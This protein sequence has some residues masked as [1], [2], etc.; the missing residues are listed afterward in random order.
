MVVFWI[1][2]ESMFDDIACYYIH[3]FY[4]LKTYYSLSI[5]PFLIHSAF[6]DGRFFLFVPGAHGFQGGHLFL[7]EGIQ[8][9]DDL[10]PK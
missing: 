9:A 7:A 2:Q 3:K 6:A 5:H 10:S 4:G 8:W 1:L